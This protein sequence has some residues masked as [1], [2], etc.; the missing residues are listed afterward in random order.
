MQTLNSFGI[1]YSYKTYEKYCFVS[2]DIKQ[3]RMLYS[4]VSNLIYPTFE[5][6][7][8]EKYWYSK[9]LLLRI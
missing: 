4:A 7:N 2:Y 3:V 5:L 1:S 9:Q 6:A 8:T